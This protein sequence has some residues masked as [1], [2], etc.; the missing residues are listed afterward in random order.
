M[1]AD[2][3]KHS[4]ALT[5]QIWPPGEKHLIGRADFHGRW[6]EWTGWPGLH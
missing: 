3:Q 6:V 5:L 1:E 4:A 2:D